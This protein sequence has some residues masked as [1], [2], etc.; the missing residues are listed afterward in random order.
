MLD[1]KMGCFGDVLT[2]QWSS[3][4]IISDSDVKGHGIES[5]RRTSYIYHCHINPWARAAH[6]YCSAHGGINISFLAE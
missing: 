5:H 2:S 3:G 1:I 4:G 6:P